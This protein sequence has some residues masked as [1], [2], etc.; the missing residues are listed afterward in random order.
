MQWAQRRDIVRSSLSFDRAG[1]FGWAERHRV[2]TVG[3]DALL[4]LEREWGGVMSFGRSDPLYR[5]YFVFGVA[6]CEEVLRREGRFHEEDTSGEKTYCGHGPNGDVYDPVSRGYPFWTWE[7]HRLWLIGEQAEGELFYEDS[8]AIWQWHLWEGRGFRVVA[9]TA[10]SF[11]ERL[12]LE[13]WI[14]KEICDYQVRFQARA[15]RE[16]AAELGLSLVPEASDWMLTT[17]ESATM[18][19]WQTIQYGPHFA[20][21][22]IVSIDTEAI[23][24]AVRIVRA[25]CPTAKIRTKSERLQDEITKAGFGDPDMWYH[26]FEEL[27]KEEEAP[28]EPPAASTR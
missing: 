24:R 9:G 28:E 13:D 15:D 17:Y 3:L 25:V 23:L 6:A 14:N 5:P 18:W 19:M 26:T 8:G 7:N 21:L 27:E 12:A 22:R 4:Q 16:V 2:P 10:R 1:L 11:F 20:E